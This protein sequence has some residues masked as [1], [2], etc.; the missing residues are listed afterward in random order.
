MRRNR[1]KRHIAMLLTTIIAASGLPGERP[2]LAAENPAL[3]TI[4]L[5]GADGAKQAT[6][7]FSLLGISWA[8]PEKPAEGTFRVRTR[9]MGSTRWTPWQTLE[10]DADSGGSTDPLWVGPSDAVEARIDGGGTQPGLRLNLINPDTPTT[11]SRRTP[12]SRTEETA[13]PTR[14]VPRMVTRAG[15]GA[16]ESIVRAAPEYTGPVQVFFVHHTATGNDYSCADSA[17]IVRGIQAYQVRTKG[18]DDI[19]YNFLVD[20]CGTIFEG[21]GGGVGR[22]VLGAHTLGFNT[23][24]SAIAVIGTY[25]SVG[26]SPAVRT[27]I[28]TVAAYKL[29]AAGN[30]PNGRVVYTSGGSNLYPVGEK[31]TLYRISGHRDAGRTDCPGDALY[32]QLPQIRAIAGAAPAGLRLLHVTGAIQYGPLLYTRGLIRPLWNVATPSALI[33]RFEVWV[34]GR[35]TLAAPGT[36]RTAALRLSPGGHTVAVR[37]LHLSGRTS[38]VTTR[39][40]SD[41]NAPTFTAGPDVALRPGPLDGSV[42]IRLGWRASDVNGLSAVSLLRPTAVNLG[43]T[44]RSR[45]GTI[46]P[47]VPTTFTVR[48]ADRAGNAVSASVTRT[49]VVLSEAVARRTGS[50]RTLRDPAY[51]GGVALGSTAGGS[52]ATWTFTGRSAA[53]AVGRG[54]F[55]GRV[56]IFVDGDDAGVVDLGSPHT[57]YRQA[58]WSRYWS[59]SAQHTIRV[60]VEGTPGRPGVILDGLV[61]L[62]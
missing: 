9:R 41:P 37:A 45:N 7:P 5:A 53:L 61:Y 29:G 13:L 10:A 42:P 54:A 26:V 11:L 52:A 55:S 1:T 21:R 3:Q 51:L 56:R 20:K 6:R 22:N 24:A 14:P 57:V 50:W 40:V 47:A 62:K 15:W 27:A 25:D 19:G 58:V 34:D 12:G 35:L 44:A 4:A 28:A 16:N 23:D 33:A 18:W 48:A 60:R 32:R 36:H 39:V 17:A 38:M 2:A 46:R 8:D 49:P 30:P 59:G 31:A 43:I